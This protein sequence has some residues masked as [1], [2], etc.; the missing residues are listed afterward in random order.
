MRLGP[1]ELNSVSEGKKEK[2]T[3]G[4]TSVSTRVEQPQGTRVNGDTEIPG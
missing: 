3:R 2:G 4:E 1:R